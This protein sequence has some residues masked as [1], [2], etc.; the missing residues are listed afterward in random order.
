M[1]RRSPSPKSRIQKPGPSDLASIRALLQ[2]YAARGAFRSFSET[3]GTSAAL[4]TF[5]F[6]W[7]RDVKFTVSYRRSTRTLT[8]VDFLPAVPARSAMDRQLRAFIISRSDKALP[9]HRR[10]DLNKVGV[11]VLNR[12]ATIS[13]AFKLQAK[14]IEYGTRKAVH[15]IHEVLMDFLNE[16][17]Y[18]QYNIDY[19]N[20]N[21]EMA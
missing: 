15:L 18:V 12:N 1:S 13:V 14:H 7:F 8:F 2:H 16:P 6:L 21:P 11:S 19:F 17:E 10:V 4:A 20:L 5:Q 3:T 9:D